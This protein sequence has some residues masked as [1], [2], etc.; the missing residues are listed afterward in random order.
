MFAGS[1]SPGSAPGV[2]RLRT[3]LARGGQTRRVSLALAGPGPMSC[4]VASNARAAVRNVWPGALQDCNLGEKLEKPNQTKPPLVRVAYEESWEGKKWLELHDM[5]AATEQ[6]RDKAKM[7]LSLPA[8]VQ[9][10]LSAVLWCLQ[11]STALADLSTQVQAGCEH[12]HR[13]A[14]SLEHN[15]VPSCTATDSTNLFAFGHLWLWMKDPEDNS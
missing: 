11:V 2:S 4:G 8:P 10:S 1:N 9:V 7:L 3:T 12:S 13:D 14:K 15:F 6:D 5:G